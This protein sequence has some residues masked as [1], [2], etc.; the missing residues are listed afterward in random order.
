MI[1]DIK[2][3]GQFTRKDRYVSGGHTTDPSYSI[4]YYRVVSIYS[5]IIAFNIEALNSIDIRAT[6]IG[7]AYLNAKFREKI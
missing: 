2:M 6:E 5:I 4:T 7:N 3:D 1:F